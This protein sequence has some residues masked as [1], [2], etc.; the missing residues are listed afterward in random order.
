MPGTTPN[1]G[2]QYPC[3]GETIN[4]AVFQTFANGVESALAAVDVASAAVLQR[5]RGAIRNGAGDVIAAGAMS[6]LVYGTTDFATGVTAGVGGF[7]ILT[8]GIYLVTLQA[9]SA[10]ISTSVTSYAADV[11]LAGT[12]AYRRKLSKGVVSSTAGDINLIGAISATAGQVVSF[13]WGWTGAGV[14]LLVLSRA[15]IRKISEL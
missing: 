5:P 9:G 15:T 1:F 7:T 8:S 12:V 3:A 11:S 6:A 4:P 13:R 10:T 14:G 2:I